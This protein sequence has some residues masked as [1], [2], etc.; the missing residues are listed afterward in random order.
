MD[1]LRRAMKASERLILKLWPPGPDAQ[2]NLASSHPAGP[3]QVSAVRGPSPAFCALGTQRCA[4]GSGPTRVMVTGEKGKKFPA[5]K[6]RKAKRLW[7]QGPEYQ[8]QYS[9]L[10]SPG[11]ML[12]NKALG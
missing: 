6:G 3:A 8:L 2:P 9:V 7:G 1:P 12:E 5:E 11:S 10:G 4:D